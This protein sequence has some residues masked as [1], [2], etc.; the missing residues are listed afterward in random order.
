MLK[1]NICLLYK[2]IIPRKHDNLCL[3]ELSSKYCITNMH[4]TVQKKEEDRSY[5]VLI[6]SQR[7]HRLTW[8]TTVVIFTENTVV[9]LKVKKGNDTDA[10]TPAV[11]DRGKSLCWKILL[12]IINSSWKKTR[13]AFCKVTA[14]QLLTTLCYKFKLERSEQNLMAI[15]VAPL[16][17]S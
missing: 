2:P 10:W 12:N 8:V 16:T 17:Q 4:N 9:Q 3:C 6:G 1:K 15:T 7:D 14:F 11:K 13:S 5:P